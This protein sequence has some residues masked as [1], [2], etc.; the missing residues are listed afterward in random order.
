[1]AVI[2]SKANR[3]PNPK[4]ETCPFCHKRVAVGT[5]Y[6]HRCCT[7]KF[8]VVNEGGQKPK[9]RWHTRP[10]SRHKQAKNWRRSRNAAQKLANRMRIKNREA[11]A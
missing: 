10:V 9:G 5:G 8:L 7:P 6:E 3:P 4:M 2:P 11:N 1:M